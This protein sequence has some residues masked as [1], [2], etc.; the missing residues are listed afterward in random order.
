MFYRAEASPCGT[1]LQGNPSSCKR[2]TRFP[3][4]FFAK[5]AQSQ[6]EGLFSCKTALPLRPFF[7]AGI[8][9]LN[10]NCRSP[11]ANSMSDKGKTAA[12]EVLRREVGYGCP[13]CRSPFLTW[14]HFDPP[15]HVE[16]HWRVA[17]IVA[18]CPLCHADADEKGTSAGA[19][20]K[21]ELRTMKK[22]NRSPRT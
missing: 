8:Y 16:K 22:S 11:R 2:T 20:S 15:E 5:L 14:H 17:G 21:E 6:S 12:M 13:V 9:H 3:G 18:M 7:V 4:V 10:R 19:Y 1:V